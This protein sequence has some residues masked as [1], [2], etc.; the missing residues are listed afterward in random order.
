MEN[1]SQ[2]LPLK[3]TVMVLTVIAGVAIGVPLYQRLLG[4]LHDDHAA[5]YEALG[6]PTIWN[7][8]IVKSWKMQR[9]LYARA[10]HRLDDPRL[11]R[12]SALLRVF[13][14][15]LVLIVFA[16]MIWWFF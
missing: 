15:V 8:S 9:F 7:R 5:E 2:D 11:D 3:L 14:P 16:Q 12:L 4:I 6:S 10:S 13:N 1:L